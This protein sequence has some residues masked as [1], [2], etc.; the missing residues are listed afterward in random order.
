MD[1]DYIKPVETKN[2]IKTMS[3]NL[4]LPDEES[5]VIWRGPILANMVKQFWSD[6]IWGELDFLFVDMPPGTGDVPLTVFQSIPVDGIVVVTSPQDLVSLIVKKALHM[7][8]SMHIPVLGVV[9]NYSYVVC[10]DCGKEFKIFGESGLDKLAEEMNLPILGRMPIEP[11][12]A[13][14]ADGHFD[15]AANHYLAMAESLLMALEG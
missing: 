4:L 7:A 10:P 12:L 9:E 11:K 8:E 2:G 6:V 13:E 1:G 15:E 5:P 3:I 14:L